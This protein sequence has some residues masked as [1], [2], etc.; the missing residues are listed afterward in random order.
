M[1]SVRNIATYQFLVCVY[2]GMVRLLDVGFC[3]DTL[4]HAHFWAC[5]GGGGGG[6]VGV[7]RFFAD[8]VIN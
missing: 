2:T 1:R 7:V 3:R 5:S 4:L 6:I 8:E